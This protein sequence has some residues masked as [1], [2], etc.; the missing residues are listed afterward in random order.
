[1][2][3]PE[4]LEKTG[5]S[6]GLTDHEIGEYEKLTANEVLMYFIRRRR[7]A[8]EKSTMSPSSAK[9]YY[10]VKETVLLEFR[11]PAVFRMPC[12]ENDQA[13]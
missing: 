5:W 10:F 8:K 6:I 11:S 9:Q 13:H 4:N 3:G 2:Q 1:M 12:S 7:I